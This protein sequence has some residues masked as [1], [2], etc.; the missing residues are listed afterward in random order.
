MQNARNRSNIRSAGSRHVNSSKKIRGKCISAGRIIALWC[1]VIRLALILFAVIPSQRPLEAQKIAQIT[2]GVSRSALNESSRASTKPG[3]ILR[4]YI[5][6]DS[7]NPAPYTIFGALVGAAVAGLWEAHAVS[8]SDDMP[9]TG[10]LL[11]IPPVAGALAGG[12]GG[13][14]LF[15][16]VH[17]NSNPD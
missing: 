6:S 5:P 15:K 17:S 16:I 7:P 4:S 9:G 8:E 12:I 13:W 14:L 11:W 10:G 1:R 2:V 3:D